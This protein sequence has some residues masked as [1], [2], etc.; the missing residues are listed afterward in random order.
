M[1]FAVIPSIRPTVLDV[2]INLMEQKLTPEK[3]YVID[4]SRT[5]RK[6]LIHEIE[7]KTGLAI[8][9]RVTIITPEENVGSAGG[10]AIGIH[11][12]LEN[13]RCEF[14]FTSDDDVLY[15]KDA[16]F[17]LHRNLIELKDAGAV[18]CAWC[19]Y[20][21]DT[22]EVKSSVWTGVLMKRKAV[23]ETGLPI[24]E[25]FL[26]GDDVEYFLRMRKRGFKVYIVKEAR[27]LKRHRSER[28][29]R[30]FYSNPSRLYYAFR[31]EVYIGLLHDIRITIRSIGYFLKNLPY[32]DMRSIIASLEGIRDGFLGKLGKKEKY[33]FQISP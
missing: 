22:R 19:E 31:N 9:E 28:T 16:I 6:E 23:A 26:Y 29:S 5:L 27:Y 2:I 15:E 20:K 8:S 4:N 12:C 32:M 17:E 10:Y 18:R 25:L 14:V 11:K 7:R 30:D 24:R 33:G 13:L 1:I 3:I 21:G